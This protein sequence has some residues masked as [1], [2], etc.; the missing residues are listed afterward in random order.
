MPV[1]N[2]VQKPWVADNYV[3]TAT[4][5]TREEAEQFARARWGWRR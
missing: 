5:A 4:F 1:I 2:G 3:E